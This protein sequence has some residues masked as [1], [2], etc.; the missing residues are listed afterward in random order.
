MAIVHINFLLKR[1]AFVGIRE[2][3][4]YLYIYIFIYIYIYLYI[5]RYI[6]LYIYI[7]IYIYI[8][9]QIFYWKIKSLS[10]VLKICYDYVYVNRHTFV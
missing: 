4:I 1:K 5:Y 2:N 7:Y 8:Y 10:Y 3:S 9:G 6:Y